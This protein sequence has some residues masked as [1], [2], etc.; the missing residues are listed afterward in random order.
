MHVNAI[1][2]LCHVLCIFGPFFFE[3]LDGFDTLPKFA[4]PALHFS[5][6]EHCVMCDCQIG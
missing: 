2:E 5:K 1:G 4:L 3:I 6:F